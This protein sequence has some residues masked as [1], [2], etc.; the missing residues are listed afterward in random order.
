MA[1]H[2]AGE[3]SPYLLQHAHNPV[4]WYPWGPEALARA[5][6][7]DR[8][9]LLSIGYSA[10]HWCHVMERESFEDEETARLMNE[11]F[12]SIK[13]DREERPDLDAIYMQAV[14]AMTGRGGWPMTVFLMPDGTPFFGGTYFPPEERHGLP[15][16]RRVLTAVSDA[17]RERRE[18][19]DKA[20][21]SMRELYRATDEGI[22]TAG[23]LGPE[24]PER[25]YRAMAQQYDARF[26]GFGAAPKFP[27][28]MALDFLL[29]W[30][31]RT[32]TTHALE[33]VETSFR[34]M[35]RGGIHDQVGGG[36]HRYTV[37]AT[38]TVP[39]FEKM[40]YDNALLARLGVHLSQATHDAELRRATEETLDWV[41]REMT[42]PEGGF[43]SALDADS[44]GVE[45]AFYVWTP[46]ELRDVLGEDD[47]GLVATYFGVSEAG[48]FE[49][50][51]V[52]TVPFDAS[53][54]AARE[55][56]SEPDL[57][58]IIAR[59]RRTLH[60]ARSARPRPGR[61]DKILASWNGLMLRAVA[62]AARAFGEARWREMALRSGDF[63]FREMVRDGRVMRTFTNGVARIGGFLEDHAAVALG[64]LSL[65]E[66]TFDARWLDRARAL[67]TTIVERFWD[68]ELGVF[69]D[70]ARDQEALVTRP[71][72]PTDNAVPSGSS[73]A[74][75]L[76]LHLGDL[77]DD[78]A[79]RRRA[80]QVLESVAEAMGRYPLAFGEM[81][82]AAEMAVAG[83]TEL[84][85]VGELGDPQ[86]VRL[87][88]EVARHY[89][90]GLV[91]A[92]G[93][94]GAR[95]GIALL[96]GRSTLGGAPTAYLCRAYACDAPVTDPD[97]LGE[98]IEQAMGPNTSVRYVEAGPG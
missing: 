6:S 55:G 34:K 93:T 41:R 59:A 63:L 23:T 52:L 25:A 66:L 79:M 35:A 77:L 4:D 44:D 7:E 49:G 78:D 37:D 8:P 24:L 21:T 40:L 60:E 18:E 97:A 10:C 29:A 57:E 69:F 54:V 61:D 19:I 3:T 1:N 30:W 11:R 88:E 86:M 32:G 39:H 36:F 45:G 28:P 95:D 87:D 46:D 80:R 90:P 71:R 65:Y 38:W 62:D 9:I 43:Y 74:T 16:F 82:Q 51:N 12:V 73:L 96:Q 22:R 75:E 20:A 26:G 33:I 68:E 67:A 2:L 47:A 42:S 83:A 70:T 89:I 13:V 98:Q 27:Q 84:A 58:A 81:L 76:L 64:A 48:N 56:V 31:R 50:K 72:D 14:Q 5:A 91:L 94:P 17:W 85:L 92:A 15:A 53:L